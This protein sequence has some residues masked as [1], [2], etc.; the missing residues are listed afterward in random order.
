MVRRIVGV[1]LGLVPAGI[2]TFFLVL[3]PLRGRLV[4]QPFCLAAVFCAAAP[5]FDD[6][7]GPGSGDG[8][9]GIGL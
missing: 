8:G 9:I 4:S 6:A 3:G 5:F 2:G 7:D 1:V